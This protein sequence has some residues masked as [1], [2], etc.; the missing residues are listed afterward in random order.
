MRSRFEDTIS[1]GNRE[2]GPITRRP[3][4]WEKPCSD[5]S[6]RDRRD[7]VV[8]FAGRKTWGDDLAEAGD[9]SGSSGLCERAAARKHGRSAFLD[10]LIRPGRFRG[11]AG[12]RC[13][14]RRRGMDLGKLTARR[15]GER[16]RMKMIG[17]ETG[18]PGCCAPPLNRGDGVR[19][20]GC[21]IYPSANWT[22]RVTLLNPDDLSLD[23]WPEKAC[24]RLPNEPVAA[25][26]KRPR[27]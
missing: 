22:R 17:Q 26:G 1:R 13:Q 9:L 25:M 18:E 6:R 20:C 12:R 24:R 11:C 19:R 21:H 10:P 16:R 15:T 2:C 14:A 5:E 4:G 8:F 23:I 7:R 27:Q 3:R